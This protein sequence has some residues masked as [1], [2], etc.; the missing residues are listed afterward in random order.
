M[1]GAAESLTQ[2]GSSGSGA[3]QLR[4]RTLG[5]APAAAGE[6]GPGAGDAFP[7]RRRRAARQGAWQNSGSGPRHEV[8]APHELAS[9][10]ALVDTWSGQTPFPNMWQSNQRRPGVAELVGGAGAERPFS[11]MW[12]ASRRRLSEEDLGQSAGYGVGIWQSHF[13]SDFAQIF[14]HGQRMRPDQDDFFEVVEA[15]GEELWGE[16]RQAVPPQLVAKPW[17]S[18]G[19]EAECPICLMSLEEG[20]LVAALPCSHAFHFE[21]IER[22]MVQAARMNRA[23]CPLCRTL[24]CSATE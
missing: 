24:V 11:H 21:C 9:D 1:A 13:P 12:Q 20:V 15:M 19:R 17:A 7:H 6:G 18:E 8:V 10:A 3:G 2:P 14:R 22:W 4:W 23:C 5:P 16:D